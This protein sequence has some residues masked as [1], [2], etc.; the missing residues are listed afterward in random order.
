MNDLLSLQGFGPLLAQGTW[1]TLKLA[2]LSLLLS[3]L[4]GLVGASA[5]LS[6]SK[7]LRIPATLYTTLIRSVPDLVLILLLF[8]SMQIWLNDLTEALGWDYVEIDPFGAGVLTLGFIYGAYFTENFRGAILSVPVG[9]LE[10]ATAYGLS[11]AQ[12]FRLVLFPQ[13][14]RF[15]L[16][17]LGNNWLVLLKST[18]LVSI[19]GLADLVK[20]AQNAGKTTNDMLSFLCLAGL[21]YLLITTLSNRLFKHLERRY[22]TGVRGLAR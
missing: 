8:Y 12:R 16:P 7:L 4:L 19:I 17:G 18:A 1:M 6:H 10:A 21:V 5:K 14:M 2:F 9:Q 22:N 20:A 15:A 13:L 11:R 3:L